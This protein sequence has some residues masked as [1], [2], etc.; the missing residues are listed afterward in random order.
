VPEFFQWETIS[1]SAGSSLPAELARNETKLQNPQISFD[2]LKKMANRLS[3]PMAR[4]R[5]SS[6]VV[7]MAHLQ[8]ISFDEAADLIGTS[9]EQLKREVQFQVTVSNRR[10]AKIK[11]LDEI[12]Q[13]LHRVLNPAA[14]GRWLHTEVPDLNG[15]TPFEAIQKGRITA[16]LDLA[17]SYTEPLAYT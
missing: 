17:H 3:S 16:V 4:R 12:L 7:F 15:L 11:R 1:D 10:L 2:Q 9:P 6:L 14:T 13:H 8:G 5:A